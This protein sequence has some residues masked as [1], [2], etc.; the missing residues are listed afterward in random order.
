MGKGVGNRAYQHARQAKKVSGETSAQLKLQ[1]IRDIHGAGK[2]VDVEIVRHRIENEAVAYEVEAAVIDALNLMG[3]QLTNLAGGHGSARGWKP[4]EELVVEYGAQP[5]E[6]APDHRVALIRIRRRFAE[7]RTP[8][9]LY[10][11]TRQWWRMAPNRRKPDWAFSVYNGIV[12]AVYR[13]DSWEQEPPTAQRK[14]RWA[15]HGTRD[16][17]MEKRYLWRDVSRY[18]SHGTQN[19]IKYVNCP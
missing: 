1:T 13:I 9:D 6:I 7:V 2:D 15:F 16:P 19:P 10:E 14:R 4:L 5:V 11:V 18:L 17:E 8:E 12:R 3:A